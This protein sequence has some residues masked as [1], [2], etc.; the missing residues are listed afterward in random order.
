[1]HIA[2]AVAVPGHNVRKTVTVDVP[3]LHIKHTNPQLRT[4]S[5]REASCVYVDMGTRSA[6][7]DRGEGQVHVSVS[8]KVGDHDFRVLR[9]RQRKGRPLAELA[10][11]IIQQHVAVVRCN[12]HYV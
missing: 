6:G 8:I 9:L 10:E 11:A 12:K 5:E 4:L 2:T 3:D 1:K 7:A